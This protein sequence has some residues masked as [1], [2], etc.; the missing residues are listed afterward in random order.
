MAEVDVA[1]WLDRL[2]RLLT[3]VLRGPEG[4]RDA[5]RFTETEVDDLAPPVTRQVNKRG[6]WL[7]A[8]LAQA[9]LLEIGFLIGEWWDRAR[10]DVAA[11]LA[12]ADTERI[13]ARVDLEPGDPGRGPGSFG[14]GGESPAP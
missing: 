13:D 2:G 8:V 1:R 14:L 7:R 4:A 9:D 5:Y 11:A 10:A 3:L 12:S 6:A